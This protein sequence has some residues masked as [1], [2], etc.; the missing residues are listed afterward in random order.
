M[1]SKN[2]QIDKPNDELQKMWKQKEWVVRW[3]D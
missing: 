3:I 2:L 1:P